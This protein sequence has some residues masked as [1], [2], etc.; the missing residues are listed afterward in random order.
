MRAKIVQEEIKHQDTIFCALRLETNNANLILLSEGEDHLGT[1]AVAMPPAQQMLGPPV[2]SLLLGDRQ[3]ILARLIAEHLAQK[4]GKIGLAS[5]F[6]RQLNDK[7]VGTVFIK[8]LDK[9]FAEQ[10]EMAQK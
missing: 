9:T 4:T 2:S 1:L 5:V 3:A 8:L 6:S 7:D 10:K